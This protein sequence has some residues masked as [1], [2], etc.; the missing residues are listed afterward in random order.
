MTVFLCGFMGC[1][2][3]VTGKALSRMLKLSLIDT[4]DEIVKQE[5]MSIPQ[6]FAE[7][8]E[9]YFRTVEAETVQKL[10]EKNA[11]VSCGGGAMLNPDTAAAAREKGAH[12]VL[13][14]QTF[15]TCY[16]RIKDDKNR[17]IVQRNTKEQLQKIFDDRAA[18]YR[19][20]STLTVSPADTPEETAERIKELLHLM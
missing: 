9:P 8:G 6:I 14:D 2:K 3:S 7:K 1:G 10:C 18:V 5:G 4:D 20:H 11:V 13:I 19:R 17:P 16:E 15:E 12:I